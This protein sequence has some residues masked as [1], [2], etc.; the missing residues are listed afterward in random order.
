ME[1][2]RLC[3]LTPFLVFLPRYHSWIFM[4]GSGLPGL[5][6]HTI[7][8]ECCHLCIDNDRLTLVDG[9]IS[10]TSAGAQHK[11]A[12]D[13]LDLAPVF[14]ACHRPHSINHCCLLPRSHNHQCSAC[15]WCCSFL[16]LCVVVAVL[17]LV[18]VPRSGAQWYQL[19]LVCGYLRYGTGR[20]FMLLMY[21]GHRLVVK[22]ILIILGYISFAMGESPFFNH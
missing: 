2:A 18:L 16:F 21:P 14:V 6:I 1:R 12:G 19:S 17:P 10:L 8:R 4:V 22:C 13:R 5:S 3:W 11:S 7:C 15:D 20:W 9:M